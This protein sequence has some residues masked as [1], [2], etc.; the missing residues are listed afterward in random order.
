MMLFF[1]I[2]FYSYTQFF[3]ESW[4]YP[5]IFG[6]LFIWLYIRRDSPH[7]WP[8][9][10]RRPSSSTNGGL[11]VRSFF[12]RC[13]ER[14]SMCLCRAG[15]LQTADLET[16]MAGEKNPCLNLVQNFLG[17]KFLRSNT[18]VWVCVSKCLCVSSCAI[19]GQ[20]SIPAFSVFTYTF[21]SNLQVCVRII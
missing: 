20:W 21:R 19:C 3:I 17:A 8:H 11:A 4:S 5:A 9:N 10:C 13:A 14:S 18:S 2:F 7:V 6:H 15:S 1:H 12:S 16:Q